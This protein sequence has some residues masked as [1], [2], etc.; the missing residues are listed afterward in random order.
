MLKEYHSFLFHNLT[1][2]KKITNNC[3]CF[4]TAFR[5]ILPVQSELGMLSLLLAFVGLSRMDVLASFSAWVQRVDSVLRFG[6]HV[7][8]SGFFGENSARPRTW[9]STRCSV[10]LRLWLRG[11]RPADRCALEGAVATAG[12][13]AS[14]SS[15]ES[16][17]S[18]ERA[19]AQRVVL[20]CPGLDIAHRR[21]VQS[22]RRYGAEPRLHGCSCKALSC[23]EKLFTPVLKLLP[24]LHIYNITTFVILL[25]HTFLQPFIQV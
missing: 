15:R 1:N 6:C 4:V 20:N 2:Q 8:S 10:M 23:D 11:E 24:G 13:V 25:I 17:D 7:V 22:E 12:S 5:S 3:V 21:L 16:R 14:R 18:R 9:V 19:R